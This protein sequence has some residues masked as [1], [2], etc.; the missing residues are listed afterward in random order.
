M[1]NEWSALNRRRMYV[2]HVIR[3]HDRIFF[4]ILIGFSATILNWEGARCERLLRNL[5]SD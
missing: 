1:T 4:L 5:L 2:S 3:V